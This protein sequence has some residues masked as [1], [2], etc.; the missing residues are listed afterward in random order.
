LRRHLLK[1]PDD[2]ELEKFKNGKSF[3]K[4]WVFNLF[5]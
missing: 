1:Y 5:L 3:L 2:Y 4:K